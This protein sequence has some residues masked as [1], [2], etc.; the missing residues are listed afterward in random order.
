MIK[1]LR[2]AN[3]TALVNM[4]W[5]RIA[6]GLCAFPFVPIVDGEFL[7]HAPSTILAAGNYPRREIL[8]GSNKDE[9][10][11]FLIYYLLDLLRLTENV[12]LFLRSVGIGNYFGFIEEQCILAAGRYICTYERIRQ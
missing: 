2:A 7:P 5:D 1:C 12:G 10:S 11:Y 6:F 4:E 3:A 9:G 8:V